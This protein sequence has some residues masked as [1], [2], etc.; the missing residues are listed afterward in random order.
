MRTDAFRSQNQ[1]EG[2]SGPRVMVANPVLD[3][4]SPF[5][6]YSTSPG[7]RAFAL[8][9]LGLMFTTTSS[10]NS[11]HKPHIG[12]ASLPYLNLIFPETRL[13]TSLKYFLRTPHSEFWSENLG[14]KVSWQM[15]HKKET[16][17]SIKALY[18]Y[19]QS[20]YNHVRWANIFIR[21]PDSGFLGS[22]SSFIF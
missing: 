10:V 20:L 1:A 12:W 7:L 13:A 4:S 22:L 2:W 14:K 15:I 16:Q 3:Q 19:F 17:T 6:Q 21:M 8:W 5:W 18:L 11:V 9:H